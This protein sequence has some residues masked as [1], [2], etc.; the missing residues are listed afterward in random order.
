[1]EKKTFSFSLIFF[2]LI[3]LANMICILAGLQKV[4]NKLTHIDEM[5]NRIIRQTETIQIK[6]ERDLEKLNKTIKN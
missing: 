1:M 6:I 3:F 5:M 2:L 4:D